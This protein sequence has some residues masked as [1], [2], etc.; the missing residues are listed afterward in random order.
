MGGI[1]KKVAKAVG[2]LAFFIP[3]LQGIGAALV[4][5][6]GVAD[7]ISQRKQA[8][9]FQ[10]ALENRATQQTI[11]VR[12][13]LVSRQIVYGRTRKGGVIFHIA[14]SSN[15][16][17]LYLVIG[18]CEGPVDAIEAIYFDDELVPLDADGDGVQAS[19]TGKYSGKVR[20]RKHYGDAAQTH[21]V[22]FVNDLPEWTTDHRLRGIAY[23]A[24]RLTF[25]PGVFPNGLPNISAVIRGRNDIFDGRDD[26]TGYTSNPS[27]CL[28]HYLSLTPFGPNINIANEISQSQWDASSNSN[29]ELIDL[30]SSAIC[31][32]EL[33]ENNQTIYCFDVAHGL[34]SGQIVDFTTN[35]S[36]PVPLVVGTDYFVREVSETTFK[37]SATRDGAPITFSDN[38]GGAIFFH[39]KELRYTFNGVVDLADNPEDIIRQFRDSMAGSVAYIGGKWYINS[40][41]YQTPPSAFE[42]DLD[43]LIGPVKFSPRRSRRERFNIVKGFFLPERSR[44][45]PADYPPVTDAA[46]VAADG[47]EE[48]AQP[49]DLPNTNT[50]TMA[51]RIAKI[52]LEKARLERTLEVEC[53]VEA[54]EVRAAGTVTVNLPRYGL[55]G[56]VFDVDQFDFEVESGAGKVS[57]SLSETSSSIYSW[58][59]VT[60]EQSFTI[61]TEPDL[62]D[63]TVSDPTGLALTNNSDVRELVSVLVEWD[64]IEDEFVIK[65]GYPEVAWKKTADADTEWQSQLVSISSTDFLVKGLEPDTF[66]DFRL[67]FRSRFGGESN[68]VAVTNHQTQAAASSAYN[69]KH[70]QA[71]PSTTWTIT[72]NLGYRPSIGGVF[73]GSGNPIVGA[74]LEGSVADPT[75]KTEIQINF[76]A[77]VSGTAY[78]S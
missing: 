15:N 77:A 47:G 51:N 67:R 58:A 61:P 70:L 8:K 6:S 9:A 72:H 7:A 44:W 76:N 1:F 35:G 28:A 33:A 73:D 56:V 31:K 40:G 53:N 39:A 49:L 2:I 30:Q 50:P 55:S 3:G 4:L 18:F 74:E 14:N 46:Y 64:D 21:D 37:V 69:Y 42:V 45:A 36:L 75:G 19:G 22:D 20:L 66:Y 59:S 11:T 62:A 29:D 25:D 57:L 63:G 38:G 32:A 71:V 65:G 34:H 60:D 13:P 27:L 26:S 48:I 12:A 17:F 5:G 41:V 52:F 10:N 68:W 23:I 16:R 78:L 54:L 24:I 43:S